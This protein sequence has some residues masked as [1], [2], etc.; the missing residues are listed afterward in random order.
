M[1]KPKENTI[2]K[3]DILSAKLITSSLSESKKELI[4][5]LTERCHTMNIHKAKLV[6]FKEIK[7]LMTRCMTAV[8]CGNLTEKEVWQSLEKDFHRLLQAKNG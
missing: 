7:V 8:E 4:A 2:A 3:I 6:Y 1:G 5:A